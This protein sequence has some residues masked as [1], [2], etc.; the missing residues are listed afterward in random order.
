M[1]DTISLA[2]F[3]H[4]DR[5]SHVIVNSRKRTSVSTWPMRND[6]FEAVDLPPDASD[7]DLTRICQTIGERRAI[8]IDDRDARAEDAC[9]RLAACGTRAMTLEDGLLG[10]TQAIV[11]ERSHR[12]G[13]TVVTS[14]VRPARTLKSYVV[15]TPSGVTVVDACGSST[16][17][18][19]ES[20]VLAGLP[21]AVVDT[22]YHRDRI[23]C[24][25][26]CAVRAEASYWVPPAGEDRIPTSVRRRLDAAREIGGLLVSPVNDGANLRL[27]GEGFSIGSHPTAT[28]PTCC[29]PDTRGSQTY[30]AVNRGL[31]LVDT[32]RRW[33]LEFGPP[34]CLPG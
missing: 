27:D 28:Y 10:W 22:A 19:H 15:V 24:G 30:D 1:T 12:H 4:I 32:G 33:Q 13:E 14:F 7:A 6:V 23:S 16:L 8:V 34:G 11:F 29:G 26:E 5:A 20:E 21:T 18:L 25:A 17:L 9:E 31:S 3:A 2:A